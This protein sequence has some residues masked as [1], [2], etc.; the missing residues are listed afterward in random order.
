MKVAPIDRAM[1]E[2]S[3]AKHSIIHTGQHYDAAMSDAFFHD[4]D[5]PAPARF[6]GIGSGTHADQTARTMIAFEKA[7]SELEPDI[8]LVVGDVNST[9]AAALVASKLGIPL[10][11]VEAGLRS[12]DRSMP[13]ELNRLATDSV[14]NYAFVTEP[15]ATA[16]LAREGW[17]RERVFWVGNTMIDTLI[18]ALAPARTLDV[19]LSMRLEPGHYALVTLHRPSNVDHLPKLR[20]LVEYLHWLADQLPV[21]FPL[22]PRTRRRLED[23]KLLPNLEGHGAIHLTAPLA[24]LRF[25]SLLASARFVVTDSGGIQEETTYLRIPCITAR[26]TTERPITCDLGTNRLCSPEPEA[27]RTSTSHV[28]EHPVEGTVPPLWDGHA[29]ERIVERLRQILE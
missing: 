26:T 2:W 20:E 13:E 19:P 24:Y 16:N 14:S 28:I 9:L 8:V 27:L 4:L 7:C 5:M 12:F 17:A 25:L 22:H 15:S 3:G 6:L 23:S 1:R 18:H 11:H 10:A 21:V 29:S